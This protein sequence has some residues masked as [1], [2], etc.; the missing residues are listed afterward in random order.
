MNVD[1]NEIRG[2]IRTVTRRTG[3]PLHDEDLEQDASLKAVEAFRRHCD[4]RNPRAF[5]MKIVRDAVHDHWRRRRFTDDISSLDEMRFAELPRFEDDLDRQRLTGFLRHALLQI[6]AGKRATIELFYSEDRSIAEIARLQN[7]SASA[8][9][10]ELM[11]AR[12]ALA[13][14]VRSLSD[15]KS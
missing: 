15:K 11:R 9:K 5:L 1:L 7:K 14:I 4:V 12:R 13:D 3:A 2:L 6:G 10:M 8:V